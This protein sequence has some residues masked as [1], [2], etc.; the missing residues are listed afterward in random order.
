MKSKPSS[1]WSSTPY[2]I[3]G[4]KSL[5]RR[6][7]ANNTAYEFTKHACTKTAGRNVAEV[8]EQIRH[9]R[10]E[11]ND[12]CAQLTVGE[13]IVFHGKDVNGNE[14]PD[15]P[16][17]LGRVMPN[18]AWSGQG[19]L[20]NTTGSALSYDMG[21]EV[22][23]NEVAIYVQCQW[24]E[25]MDLNSDERKYRVNGTLSPSVQNNQ[26]LLHTGLKMQQML[27]DSNPVA[28]SRPGSDRQRRTTAAASSSL[29]EYA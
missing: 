22:Q 29:G 10:S 4:C 8:A 21:V 19:V 9:E 28:R 20:R 18:P 3:A 16:I 17:W 5:S 6:H 1:G 12:V 2:Q 15:Q 7:G 26:L 11:L 23:N 25:K 13:W 24:Y 14:D 27:G